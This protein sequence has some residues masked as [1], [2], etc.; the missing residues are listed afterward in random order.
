M[1]GKGFVGSTFV[2]YCEKENL[3]FQV[4]T[5]ENYDELVGHEC[6]ILINANGNSSKVLAAKQPSVDFDKTVLSVKK[7]L[8]D[9]KFKKYILISSCDVYP[10]CSSPKYTAE[11]LKIDVS[12]QSSYGSHKYLAE[13]YVIQNT[14]KWLIFRLGGMVGHNLKKNSIYDII[15]GGPLWLDPQSQ[16]Q[17]MNTDNVAQ[18]VFTIINNNIINNIFNVCGNGLVKLQD[19]LETH[20][21]VEIKPNSPV[22]KYNINIEKLKKILTV[23]DSM[24]TVKTFI[25][26]QDVDKK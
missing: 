12:K 11:D 21:D 7:T 9:F 4:I 13:Q 26:T 1:G 24:N 25:K 22:V 15:H 5:R 8:T 23:P 16:L 2:R 14:K 10:D 6:D 17:F 3:E 20:N 19:L 18:I